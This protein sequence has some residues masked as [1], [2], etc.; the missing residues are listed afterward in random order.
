[1]GYYVLTPEVCYLPAQ[2]GVNY[3]RNPGPDTYL[4]AH[5]S[6]QHLYFVSPEF[7]K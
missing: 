3:Q 6:Y 4:H 7:G 1:M 2:S 5:L